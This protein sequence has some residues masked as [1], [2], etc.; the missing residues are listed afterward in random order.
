MRRNRTYIAVAALLIAFAL[1]AWGRS[2]WA[3]DAAA[4]AIAAQRPSIEAAAPEI[5]SRFEDHCL[6]PC[7]L[8]VVRGKG[9]PRLEPLAIMYARPGPEG[10]AAPGDPLS[11]AIASADDFEMNGGVFSGKSGTGASGIGGRML[12]FLANPIGRPVNAGPAGSVPPFNENPG[13]PAA[14]GD[15]E[16]GDPE[17]PLGEVPLI[18]LNPP[19]GDYPPTLETP[20]PGSFALFLSAV[21]GSFFARRGQKT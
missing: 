12:A 10:D 16:P 1:I 15:G 11:I 21:I 8:M 19:G 13:D 17:P 2:S 7:E 18:D 3:P 14:P 5:V 6:D 20:L 9:A 4:D